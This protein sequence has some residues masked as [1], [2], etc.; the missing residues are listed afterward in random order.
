M[1]ADLFLCD[2]HRI[3][4]TGP[5]RLRRRTLD[6]RDIRSGMA[7]VVAALAAEG[8]EPGRA[9]SRRSSAATRSSSNGCAASAPPSS[10]KA[11]AGS[12]AD[13]PEHVDDGGRGEPVE[14]QGLGGP[15]EGGQRLLEPGLQ[16]PLPRLEQALLRA[17]LEHE[18][19]VRRGRA[20][21]VPQ[22]APALGQQVP[23]RLELAPV[24]PQQPP[25]LLTPAP[26]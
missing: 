6:S 16:L 24:V 20:E 17:E 25:R 7:L 11:E 26:R 2:P 23:R 22:L 1:G 15:Q 21:G 3:V 13:P 12:A 4:V 14:P 8:V 10:A 5:R 18:R 9:R 19:G